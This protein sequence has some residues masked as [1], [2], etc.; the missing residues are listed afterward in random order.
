MKHRDTALKIVKEFRDSLLIEGGKAVSPTP[1]STLLARLQVKI[2]LA[3]G[4][5]LA[6]DS[7]EYFAQAA[8]RASNIIED[9]GDSHHYLHV[10][11]HVVEAIK[12]VPAPAGYSEDSPFSVNRATR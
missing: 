2:E 10:R 6:R 4:D 8:Q 12:A 1:W 5:A 11:D 9:L 7:E 3:I